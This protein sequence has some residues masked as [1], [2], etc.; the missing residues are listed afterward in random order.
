MSGNV[1][2]NPGP[3]R[4]DRGSRHSSKSSSRPTQNKVT[5]LP[6]WISH[7]SQSSRRSLMHTK[8]LQRKLFKAELHSDFLQKYKNNGVIPPGLGLN[9]QAQIKSVCHKLRSRD[10]FYGGRECSACLPHTLSTFYV[11]A[12]STNLAFRPHS[13]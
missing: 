4:S 7:L 6:D 2:S 3:Q 13:K 1:H 12:A 8:N 10:P 11:E 5:S 9:K